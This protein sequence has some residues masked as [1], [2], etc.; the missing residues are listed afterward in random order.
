MTTTSRTDETSSRPGGAGDRSSRNAFA[1]N[2]IERRSE[3]RGDPAVLAEALADVRAGSFLFVG[4]RIVLD[5][6]TAEPALFD[7]LRAKRLGADLHE[8]VLLGWMP[9]GAPRFAAT[10]PADPEDG[11]TLT[12]LRSLALEGLVTADLFGAVAQARSLL[13]WHERH[14]FCA[15]CGRATV[16]SAAGYR[17]DCAHCGAQHFPRT[18]PVVIMLVTDGSRCLLGRQPRFKPGSYSCLAGFLEPGETIEDAVRRETFEESGVR[19]GRVTYRSSQPWPFP[20]SLM[21]GCEAAAETTAITMDTDELED[22]RWFD[23]E[24]VA[25][26]VAGTHKDGLFTPPRTAIARLLVEDWLE[27]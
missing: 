21:I 18:D 8:G 13:V 19:V 25:A 20:S 16:P 26:M 3:K 14:G 6:T 11:L 22:C 27:G 23:R 4:E 24:E 15:N 5:P 7:L 17:R 10:L 9:D 2:P 12:D 1:V